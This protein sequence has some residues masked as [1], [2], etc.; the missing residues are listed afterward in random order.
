MRQFTPRIGRRRQV[1]E[2]L[3][4][5]HKSYSSLFSPIGQV[6]SDICYPFVLEMLVVHQALYVAQV[7]FRKSIHIQSDLA[8]VVRLLHSNHQDISGGL[9]LQECRSLYK[10]VPLVSV[11][12]ITRLHN[13]AAHSVA[14]E[15]LCYTYTSHFLSLA[16]CISSTS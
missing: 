15:A 7:C 5:V 12:H 14:C 13:C 4:F 11:S 10:Y 8:K 9:V 2:L 1:M 3:V 16:Y 6:I